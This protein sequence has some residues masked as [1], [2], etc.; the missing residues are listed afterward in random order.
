M[1]TEEDGAHF[2]TP[3]LSRVHSA[4][5]QCAVPNSLHPWIPCFFVHSGFLFF[6][7][8]FF[9]L[10]SCSPLSAKHH[11]FF[12][13]WFHMFSGNFPDLFSL[14][15]PLIPSFPSLLTFKTLAV[16][17]YMFYLLLL[18]S[19]FIAAHRFSQL[20]VNDNSFELAS[21]KTNKK[22]GGMFL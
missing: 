2:S 7:F 3:S 5:S 18:H 9:C 22:W 16:I 19:M 17:I 13:I 12:S 11:S 10:E 21:N 1:E 14:P 20:W 6:F 8:S 4:I 15:P